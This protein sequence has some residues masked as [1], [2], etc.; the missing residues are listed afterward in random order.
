MI[1]RCPHCNGQHLDFDDADPRIRRC[2]ECGVYSIADD[3]QWQLGDGGP[4][5]LI[6]RPAGA[7][8]PVPGV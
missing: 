1:L 6:Q 5:E 2:I 4:G 8:V 7:P 3:D